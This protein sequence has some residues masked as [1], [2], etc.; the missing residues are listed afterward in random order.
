M[1]LVEVHLAACLKRKET[2]GQFIR[3]DYT[4]KDP[5]RDNM[6][7]IQRLE[8]GQPVMEIREAPDLKPEYLKEEK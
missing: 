1:D 2:R 4:E 3:L 5:S 8:N 6:I 7:T